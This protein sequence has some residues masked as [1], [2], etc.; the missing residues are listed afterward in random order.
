MKRNKK[1]AV[2]LARLLL[3]LIFFF[4]GYGKVFKIGLDNVYHN[5]FEK[6][7][8]NLLPE[9]LL[10]FTAYY[11]SIVELLAGFFLIIGFKRDYALYLLATVLVIVSFGHGFKNPIWDLSDVMYRTVL[12]LTLLVLPKNLD[13]VSVDYFMNKVFKKKNIV[14]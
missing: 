9:F 10:V 11:T 13:V 4:Q 1:V 14:D 2:L 7:Y 6:S 8:S 5:F 3:G 12:L